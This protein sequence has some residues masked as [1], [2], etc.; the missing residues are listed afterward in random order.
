MSIKSLMKV[1]VV[2]AI[3]TPTMQVPAF[4]GFRD[5]AFAAGII[6]AAIGSAI[7]MQGRPQAPAF[8]RSYHRHAKSSKPDK[9]TASATAAK[10]PFAGA[11]APADYAKPVSATS[12]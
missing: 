11:S 2:A 7:M 10:D 5:G 6:G 4:A 9:S 12:R 8:H 3:A 1:L